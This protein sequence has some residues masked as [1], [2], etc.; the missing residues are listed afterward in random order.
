MTDSHTAEVVL[1]S[2]PYDYPPRPSI[3]LG[4]FT[5]CLNEAGISSVTLYPMF[6][7]A[8]LTGMDNA[9]KFFRLPPQAMF[10]E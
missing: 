5:V 7:M 1:L 4:I 8:E 3:A 6:R 9:M 10:E 2:P